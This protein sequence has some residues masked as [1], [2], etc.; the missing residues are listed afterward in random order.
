M[1]ALQQHVPALPCI[2]VPLVF[3]GPDDAAEAEAVLDAEAQSEVS[4][5]MAERI[6]ELTEKEALR[7][8]E[9]IF[10]KQQ[11]LPALAANDLPK[12]TA[13]SVPVALLTPIER[14]R[15]EAAAHSRAH[16]DVRSLTTARS[17][18]LLNSKL[19]LLPGTL[20]KWHTECAAARQREQE[21]DA[22]FIQKFNVMATSAA[23]KGTGFSLR[24]NT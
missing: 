13:L 14:A 6:A 8:D 21:D 3:V 17:R 5:R 12:R 9:A 7:N 20:E 23:I 10:F 15:L 2:V 1:A 19:E 18:D 16:A 4:R 11:Q 24:S 22:T